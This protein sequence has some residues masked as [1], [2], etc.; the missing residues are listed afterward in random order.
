MN[1]NNCV[2]VN[3]LLNQT[4][5]HHHQKKKKKK[6]KC[7][8]GI[9]FCF[10]CLI[11]SRWLI[12]L[13]STSTS[14]WKCC[15]LLLPP[16]LD[17]TV[18]GF[19]LYD[20]EK[21]NRNANTNLVFYHQN[22]NHFS[23]TIRSQKNMYHTISRK[24]RNRNRITIPSLSRFNINTSLVDTKNIKNNNK[25]KFGINRKNYYLKSLMK[26]NSDNDNDNDN[27]SIDIETLKKK[28]SCAS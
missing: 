13:I 3:I 28:Y 23:S 8:I 2:F 16:I 11:L 12:I 9:P 6:K 17:N 24:T 15:F 22:N 10:F 18:D 5:I 26:Y 4:K 14:S 7:I 19:Q 20:R 27:I 21:V 1:F 25:C